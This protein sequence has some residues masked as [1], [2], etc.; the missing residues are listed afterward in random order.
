M[1]LKVKTMKIY[2]SPFEINKNI[3]VTIL[4]QKGKDRRMQSHVTTKRCKYKSCIMHQP[5]AFIGNDK[6]RGE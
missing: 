3:P 1:H 2:L 5:V 4:G 6:G